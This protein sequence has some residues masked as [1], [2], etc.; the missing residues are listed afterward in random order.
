MN[1]SLQIVKNYVNGLIYV[2]ISKYFLQ[3]SVVRE[4]LSWKK[5]Q[6]RREQRSTTVC[7]HYVE[8]TEEVQWMVGMKVIEDVPYLST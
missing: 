4:L 7:S 3:V 6:G 8:T 2:W 1:I 5:A